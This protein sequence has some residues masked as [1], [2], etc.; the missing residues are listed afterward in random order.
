VTL[1]KTIMKKSPLVLL[2]FGA[3]LIAVNTA[4]AQS[5][6][7]ETYDFEFIGQPLADPVLQHAKETYVLFGCAYCH[8]VNL[9]ARGEATDL[10]HSKLVGRDTDGKLI[11]ALLRSGIPQT[12]KLS[13]MPQFSDLSDQQID[14]LVRWI[15]YARAQGRFRELSEAKDP[16]EGNASSGKTYFDE[17]CGSCHSTT[18]DLAGIGKKYDAATLKTRFLRPT[19]LD[20]TKSWK[21]DQLHDTKSEAARAQHQRLMENYS[22]QDTFD[23]VAYLSSLK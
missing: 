4:T 19:M 14:N 22:L 3:Y 10:M 16:P 17:K 21:L 12:A 6:S 23:V 11:G 15:H 13:P 2:A 8:G 5:V 20:E 7:K 18:G 1:A 9:V